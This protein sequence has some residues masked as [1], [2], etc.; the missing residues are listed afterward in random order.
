MLELLDRPIAFHRILVEWTGSVNAALMLSQLIYWSKRTQD[1]E[2]WVYK[3]AAHWEEETGLS[4]REQAGARKQLRVGGWVEEKLKGVPA[5]L[6]YR[7]CKTRFDKTANL[8]ST[9]RPIYSIDYNKVTTK[10][11]GA[12]KAPRPRAS[13]GI[14]SNGSYKPSEAAIAHTKRFFRLLSSHKQLE[15][16]ADLPSGSSDASRR[17]CIAT[18]RKW[19]QACDQLIEK[20]GSAKPI[21]E[22]LEWYDEHFQEEWVPT[23]IAMT[24]FCENFLKLKKAML[25]DTGRS[26]REEEQTR[27][28]S[29]FEN[30]YL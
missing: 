5:T 25:R 13:L 1:P 15:G 7:I 18:R 8:D 22:V 27:S 17:K 10:E 9:K 23:H 2:G 28:E 4:Q 12:A 16:R 14:S 26:A 24:T 19:L 30:P 11:C 29:E 3:T 6:H 21:A 20:L